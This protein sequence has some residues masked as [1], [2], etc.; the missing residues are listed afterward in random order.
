MIPGQVPRPA[1][2]PRY[3]GKNP[4]AFREKYKE[5][6]P[7]RYP[8]TARKVEAEGKTPAG[9]HRPI[10]VEEILRILDPQPGSKGV[11][12]TL[13]YGGHASRILERLKPG[14]FLLGLD[15]D[16]LQLPRTETRL[17]AL[18]FGPETLEVLQSNFAGIDRLIPSRWVE[19]V[20]FIL[21][22]LGCSS[23]QLDDPERGFTFKNHGPLDMRMNPGRG[24]SAARWLATVRE[25]KL[26]RALREFGDVPGA[27]EVARTLCEARGKKPPETTTDLKQLVCR[28]LP[29]SDG[30]IRN[31]RDPAV[32][33]VIRRVFQAVRIAVNDEFSAL[34]TFLRVVPRCLKPGGR[35]AVLTFHSGEDRR[36]KAAFKQGRSHGVY[37]AISEEILRPSAEEIRGNPRAS[38]AK[39]RWAIRASGAVPITESDESISEL[40][41]PDE[42]A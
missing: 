12:A 5:L 6:N 19:G 2:R 29:F 28:A 23:M 20:D 32:E 31:S 10:C 41:M 18:G 27:E 40:S 11:D 7:D 14:G 15:A 9:T 33:P 16:V 13:G 35:L 26:T 30:R 4:R 1:R 42:P 17:R 36:V 39:L 34:E 8:E 24:S 37:A 25:D 3:A 38:S 22:D 21:A